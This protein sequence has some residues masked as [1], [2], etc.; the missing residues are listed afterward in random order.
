MEGIFF[1]EKDMEERIWLISALHF[2][3]K[4][5]DV[6]TFAVFN[7]QVETLAREKKIYFAE[8]SFNVTISMTLNLSV[9][10]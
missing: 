10:Q 4:T 9:E 8:M 5:V 1:K 3:N 7:C 2:P 6:F